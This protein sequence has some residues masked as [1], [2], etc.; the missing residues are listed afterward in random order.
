M[1]GGYYDTHVGVTLARPLVIASLPGG[2]GDDVAQCVAS[3]TGLPF[4]HLDEQLMHRTG[5]SLA[6]EVQE[7]GVARQQHEK[8]HVVRRALARMPRPVIALGDVTLLAPEVWTQVVQSTE[9]VFI[10][11]S[12]L[13]LWALL[14]QVSPMKRRQYWQLSSGPFDGFEAVSH[15]FADSLAA[16]RRSTHVVSGRGRSSSQLA[17]D[18]MVLL[19][20]TSSDSVIPVR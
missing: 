17:R 11:W 5:R 20:L 8:T 15:A 12:D 18:L 10:D 16:L 9:T 13:E 14:D 6:R 3:M 2:R 7:S 4:A 19:H 1:M